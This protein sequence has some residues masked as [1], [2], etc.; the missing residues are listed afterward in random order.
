MRQPTRF[1]LITGLL[2]LVVS[3]ASPI[4]AQYPD[5]L[6]EDIPWIPEQWWDI[7][8]NEIATAYSRARAGENR[9]LGSDL[10]P[11]AFPSQATWDSWHD[12]EKAIFIIN[13]ERRARGII[14]LESIDPVVTDVAQT[15]A[16]WLLENDGWGHEQDVDGDGVDESP[17]DRLHNDSAIAPA[18]ISACHDFLGIGE[19][20]AVYVSSNPNHQPVENVAR[21]IYDWLYAD[22]SSEWGHRHALLWEDFA[23]NSGEVGREG[24]MGIAVV[25]N[26]PYR[27]PFAETWPTAA[28]I[29]FNVY[30]PCGGNTVANVIDEAAETAE[31]MVIIP[32][33]PLS[34]VRTFQTGRWIVGFALATV[35]LMSLILRRK[36]SRHE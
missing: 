13:E 14:E 30:D 12:N 8:L 35:I 33:A 22:A 7:S 24:A 6:Q 17:W 2:L 11:I 9:Q 25:R 4:H 21:A 31:T 15:F 29:V 5:D 26:G 1:L 10:E 36:P 19:N 27:G 18:E 34:Q 16:H 23:D 32:E 3:G 28:M 20:L